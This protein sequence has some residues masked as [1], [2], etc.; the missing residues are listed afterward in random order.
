MLMRVDH[1]SGTPLGEQIAANVRAAFLRGE[2]KPGDRLPS[3][4]ALADSVDVNLH[5][6]LR[7]Y[8]TLRNEGLI[9]LRRGRGAIVRPDTSPSH[10]AVEQA[11]KDYVREARSWGLSTQQM[12]HLVEEAAK[13]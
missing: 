4:R 8:A 11:A 1:G 9:E 12:L 5:T 10:T 13:K 2:V 7:A 6:V 3:A